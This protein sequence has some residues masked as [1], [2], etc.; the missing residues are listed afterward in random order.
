MHVMKDEMFALRIPQSVDKHLA[1]SLHITGLCA[2]SPTV[3]FGKS[4]WNAFYLRLCQCLTQ[5]ECLEKCLLIAS[6]HIFVCSA[7]GDI[8]ELNGYSKLQVQSLYLYPIPIVFCSGVSTRLFHAFPRF[9]SVLILEPHTA[10]ILFKVQTYEQFPKEKTNMYKNSISFSENIQRKLNS[11]PPQQRD[12]SNFC[13]C[14]LRS[15]L[16]SIAHSLF[17]LQMVGVNYVRV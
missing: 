9:S 5:N 6:S 12:Q 15:T 4:M 8:L 17:R 3:P 16:H 10:F 11:K 14:A 13:L 2:C 7:F 1:F